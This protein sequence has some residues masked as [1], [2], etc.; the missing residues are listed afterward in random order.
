MQNKLTLAENSHAHVQ[1]QHYS[2]LNIRRRN[3]VKLHLL[4]HLPHI[5]T[6]RRK[7]SKRE[8][9]EERKRGGRKREEGLI[10]SVYN[11]AQH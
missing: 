6:E 1:H 4:S 9:G 5:H 2:A 10:N 3:C 11:T 7:E 8:A